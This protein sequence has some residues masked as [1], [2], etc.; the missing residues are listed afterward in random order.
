M[1]TDLRKINLEQLNQAHVVAMLPSTAPKKAEKSASSEWDSSATMGMGGLLIEMAF[2]EANVLAQ[3]GA[4]QNQLSVDSLDAQSK[5]IQASANDQ[6]ES[7]KKDAMEAEYQAIQSGISSGVMG[8]QGAAMVKATAFDSDVNGAQNDLKALSSTNAKLTEQINQ[9]QA[10]KIGAVDDQVAAAQQAQVESDTALQDLRNQGFKDPNGTL[11][12]KLTVDDAVQAQAELNQ[13]TKLATD[14]LRAATSKMEA[15]TTK[16]NAA[17]QFAT[18]GSQAVIQGAYITSN[19]NEKA[20]IQ[21]QATLDQASADM[22]KQAAQNNSQNT[23]Q[24]LQ[25]REQMQNQVMQAIREAVRA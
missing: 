2:K 3:M 9:P 1:S 13:E 6:E 11:T 15:N 19:R 16:Y 23:T 17:G 21:A 10:I 8:L 14:R 22:W 12:Q 20:T 4:L 18:N 5:M 25:E 7:L 24:V